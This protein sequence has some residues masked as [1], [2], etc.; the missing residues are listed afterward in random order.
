VAEAADRARE[1]EGR[2]EERDLMRR[3]TVMLLEQNNEMRKSMRQS[4]RQSICAY[5]DDDDEEA[6]MHRP[7]GRRGTVIVAGKV[8]DDDPESYGALDLVRKMYGAPVN[9][10]PG[11]T[12]ED[13]PDW[14]DCS[15]SDSSEGVASTHVFEGGD[16][17]IDAG[18][19]A[20]VGDMMGSSGSAHEAPDSLGTPASAA[21]RK[22]AA[23]KGRKSERSA[24]SSGGESRE[25]ASVMRSTQS[26]WT[27]SGSRDTEYRVPGSS[28]W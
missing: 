10:D 21:P 7:S 20:M 23:V 2:Q 5:H 13:F 26:S 11:C 22:S 25:T 14:S 12:S 1:A 9:G 19:W 6:L 8:V 24:T 28:S 15:Y 17:E 3:Q 4:M 27:S 16:G 18:L